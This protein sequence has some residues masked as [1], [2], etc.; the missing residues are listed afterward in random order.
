MLLGK[1]IGM[2]GSAVGG[3][4]GGTIGAGVAKA[5]SHA[6]SIL[7]GASAMGQA[8]QEA[9]REGY[10]NKAATMY[11]L[12]NGI[13]ETILQEKVGGLVGL[14]DHGVFT[15]AL[16]GL[17]NKIPS[18]MG[19]WSVNMVLDGLSEVGQELFGNVFE[20]INRTVT[21]GEEHGLFDNF[22]DEAG[23][24]VV[25]TLLSTWLLNSIGLGGAV[26]DSR[27]ISRI[28]ETANISKSDALMLM[29]VTRA[30]M[31][32]DKVD[33][34]V[35]SK[36]N[37]LTAVLMSSVPGKVRS[38]IEA[39]KYTL[40]DWFASEQGIVQGKLTGKLT[41]D[42]RTAVQTE[43]V[44]H[45]EA[46]KGKTDEQRRDYL[47]N[48]APTGKVGNAYYTTTNGKAIDFK[49]LDTTQKANYV[50]AQKC[51]KAF[52]GSV[53]VVIHDT[54]P[55]SNGAMVG[56]DGK[57]HIALDVTNAQG[58]ESIAYWT[59]A[60]EA[61]HALKIADGEAWNEMF[62]VLTDYAKNHKDRDGKNLYDALVDSITNQYKYD[63]NSDAFNDEMFSLI[64]ERMV[65]NEGEQWAATLGDNT[66][67]DAIAADKNASA[68]AKKGFLGK[69]KASVEKLSRQ[70]RDGGFSKE[71]RRLAKIREQ[72]T[73]AYKRIN[74]APS[75]RDAAV[76]REVER[77]AQ[78]ESETSQKTAPYIDVPADGVIPIRATSEKVESEAANG[79]ASFSLRYNGEI[80]GRSMAYRS[81]HAEESADVSDDMLEAANDTIND[82]VKVMLPY[83]DKKNTQ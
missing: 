65:G 40:A 39:K 13:S 74:E 21:L 4:V 32:G 58:R 12:Y 47:L 33:P 15:K 50:L 82:M 80:T 83:L 14:G 60:H 72:L 59:L 8:K 46:L 2:V 41:K 35:L 69:L 75:I 64:A 63:N 48:A 62:N 9:L 73:E 30:N 20:N 44:D 51:A 52:E 49:N 68:K 53:D 67:F 29:D 45:T 18:A 56:S 78:E 24:T 22:K 19:R 7:M 34:K 26:R 17:V 81:N 27:M 70:F 43:A 37:E 1:G 57:L 23:Q 3:A 71:R 76:A 16:D 25:S 10:G 31:T 28:A 38:D 77:K 36:Y 61:G 79:D 66:I 6:G 42:E 55:L 11:G 54:L 5:A